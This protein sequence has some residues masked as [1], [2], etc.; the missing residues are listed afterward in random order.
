RKPARALHHWPIP[1]AC[2]NL[3]FR[4]RCDRPARWRVLYRLGRL[5]VPQPVPPRGGGPAGGQAPAA[6]AAVGESRRPPPPP[7]RGRGAA[8]AATPR[9][10]PQKTR[11]VSRLSA[12]TPGSWK[13]RGAAPAPRLLARAGLN[14][15][16]AVLIPELS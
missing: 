7:P 1:R 12:R 9:S 13:P 3:L 14:P 2:A 11:P 15:A 16:P 10:A 5:G 8:T 6:R 4:Q